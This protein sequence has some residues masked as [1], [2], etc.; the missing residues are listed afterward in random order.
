MSSNYLLSFF[1]LDAHSIQQ[2]VVLNNPMVHIGDSLLS[3]AVI[4]AGGMGNVG[5]DVTNNFGPIAIIPNAG[6]IS[7]NDSPN[8]SALVLLQHGINLSGAVILALMQRP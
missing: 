3:A 8:T 1:G 7:I 6:N 5:D 2:A 4:T